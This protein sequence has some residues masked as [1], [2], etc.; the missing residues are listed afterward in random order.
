LLKEKKMTGE[1]LR[2][3]LHEIVENRCIV[4]AKLV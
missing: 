4:L 2:R 3:K 1:E